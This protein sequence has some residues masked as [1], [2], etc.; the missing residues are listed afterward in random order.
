METN[1][2]DDAWQK[3][4][5]SCILDTDIGDAI[6]DAWALAWIIKS[7]S[8]ALRL[9]VSSCGDTGQLVSRAEVAAQ[10]LKAGGVEV[11]VV[12]G[13]ASFR[14]QEQHCGSYFPQTETPTRPAEQCEDPLAKMLQVVHEYGSKASPVTIICIG[15]AQ[16]VAAAYERYGIEFA[17]RVRIVGMYGRSYDPRYK[18]QSTGWPVYRAS[19]KWVVFNDYNSRGGVPIRKTDHGV[20]QAMAVAT[21]LSAPFAAIDL[22]SVDLVNSAMKVFPAVASEALCAHR[23]GPDSEPLVKVILEMDT[24]YDN[25]IHELLRE[26]PTYWEDYCHWSEPDQKHVALWDVAVIAAVLQQTPG[27]HG[28]PR[29][30]WQPLGVGSSVRVALSWEE[31]QDGMDGPGRIWRAFADCV[32][33]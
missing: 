15:A 30:R 23:A 3:A 10:I 9:V 1:S 32:A 21:I 11:P 24:L 29:P 12:A 13:V 6:D 5:V 26:D 18:E 8:L 19:D 20:G 4:P 2:E 27:A 33:P 17:E 31:G 14:C 22:C 7:T 25:K 28:L 16:N